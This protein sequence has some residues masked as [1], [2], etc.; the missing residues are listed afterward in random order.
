MKIGIHHS[1]GSYSETWIAYCKR[2]GI[3]YK[4]INCYDTDIIDQV[5]DCDFLMWHWFHSDPKV[6]L[7]ARQLVNSFEK[8]GKPVYP[9]SDSCWHYDD[10]VGQKYLLEAVNAP[11]VPSYVFYDKGKAMDWIEKAVFPKVFKL[12]G[13]YGS[14]NVK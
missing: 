14:N 11:L 13:G 3:D 4:I 8:L 7:M 2:H 1:K 9:N 10:K 5:R 12:R 6:F